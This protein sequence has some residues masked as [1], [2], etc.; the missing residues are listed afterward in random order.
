MHG[1]MSSAIFV[2]ID[3]RLRNG[4]DTFVDNIKRNRP[5]GRNES[6]QFDEE[7]SNGDR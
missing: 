7:D 5:T 2:Q 4:G 1:A 6:V 3:S